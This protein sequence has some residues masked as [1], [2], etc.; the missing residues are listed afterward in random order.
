M[1]T[2]RNSRSFVLVAHDP[3]LA[4]RVRRILVP[5]RRTFVARDA[6]EAREMLAH[7]QP[8]VGLLI[9]HEV[10]GV[11]GLDVLNAARDV[12][13]FVPAVLFDDAPGSDRL[14]RGYALRASH[15]GANVSAEQLMPFVFRAL[16]EEHVPDERVG[17][18]VESLVKGKVLTL[19]EAELLVCVIADVPREQIVDRMGISPNTLKGHVR[20]LLTK[21]EAGD[22]DKL[23]GRIFRIALNSGGRFAPTASGSR[24]HSHRP[25]ALRADKPRVSL[26]PSGM[27]AAVLRTSSTPPPTGR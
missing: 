26:R 27:P 12:H 1:T 2:F 10:A 25:V 7:E 3:A 17:C 22:L 5:Y 11:D 8:P 21:L 16:T 4:Q 19:R 18:L 24:P 15:L 14:A 9:E 23:A 20:A 6:V 13:P